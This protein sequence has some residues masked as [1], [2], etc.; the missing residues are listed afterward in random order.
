MTI[1]LFLFNRGELATPQGLRA[2][3]VLAEQVGYDSICLEDH[4]VAPIH[5]DASY[6]YHR[7]GAWTGLAENHFEMLSSLAYLAGIT[8]R[9]RVMT[10]V[11]VAPYRNPVYTAK[12]LATIDNLSNGRL[13][14]GVGTGWMEDE[15]RLLGLD[16]FASRGAVTNEYLRL[17]NAFWME[18]EPTFSG[19]YVAIAGV[20]SAP[21]PL[22]KPR[23]PIW[24]G[25]RSQ[26]AIAR[27]AELGDVWF[28]T[29]YRRPKGIE[30]EDSGITVDHLRQ[31]IRQLRDQTSAHG[32]PTGA[33]EIG[34]STD[35]ALM[36]ERQGRVRR[37]FEGTRD[38]VLADFLEYQE[39]GVKHFVVTFRSPGLGELLHSI[40]RFADVVLP[41]LKSE[42][43]NHA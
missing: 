4:I 17:F 13:I 33:V 6:P 21:R 29:G 34:L 11:L 31:G 28:P 37:P 40:A 42:G 8:D 10:H 26:A 22:Q 5:A 3:A 35:V 39:I 24:V 19:R 23:P 32:R 36:P 16:N 41:S 38:S 9:I 18:A 43:A 25:G 7:G 30:A 27:A 15:F 2:S 14:I 12:A 20:H 1:G